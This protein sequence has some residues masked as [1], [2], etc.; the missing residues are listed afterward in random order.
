[1]TGRSLPQ[2]KRFWQQAPLP[3]I[4]L[5]VATL[6]V[7]ATPASVSRAQAWKDAFE[8][9]TYE[10]ANK[11]SMPYRLLSPKSIEPGKLYPFVL[12]LHGV[13][14]R[15]SNNSRQMT[16]A[17]CEFAK[18]ENREKHPC[19][20]VAPQCPLDD[21]WVPLP[22]LV[23]SLSTRK[24][25]TPSL[26]LALELYEKLVGELPVDRNR[27]YITG[28]SMGGF[29]VWDTIVRRPDYF[30]AA[31]PLCGGGDSA[32]A[33]RLKDLPIWAF[34]G[35]KDMTVPCRRTT[36]MIDAIRKAGGAPK[37]TIYPG[38]G[39]PCWLH[40]FTDPE[41][42]EWLFAQERLPHKVLADREG[43]PAQ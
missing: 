6:V 7:A 43:P 33:A 8:T 20:V 4:V 31:M 11:Q 39:H 19:F 9:R 28:V 5:G 40:A 23:F 10:N 18:P 37:M 21:G 38:V 32:S 1:M 42:F 12:F 3:S 25:P 2:Q 13:G 22:G 27:L 16:H 34:H 26:A 41:V 24:K 17:V 35:E 36:A 29:G 30:T 14:E 15:G